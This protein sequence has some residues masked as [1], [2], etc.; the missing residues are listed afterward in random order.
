MRQLDPQHRGLKRVEAPVP[1]QVLVVVLGPLAIVAHH[2]HLLGQLP[3]IRRERAGVAVSSQVLARIEAEGAKRPDGPGAAPLVPGA[4]GL[5][6]VLDHR[7][8]VPGGDLEDRVHVGRLAVQVDGHDR[9]GA[10]RDGRFDQSRIDVVRARVDVDP[11]G[12][13]A[14]ERNC[15]RA[16]D[17]RSRRRDHLVARADVHRPHAQ[18]ERGHAGIQAHRVLRLAVGAKLAFEGGDVT[19][20]D[21]VG[22]RDHPTDR[23]LDLCRDGGLLRL[24]V[25]EWE[26]W[27]HAVP[28]F[29]R[30]MA[31]RRSP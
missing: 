24:Q 19:S 30:C 13:R 25:N 5:A 17:E 22:V 8:A 4:V 9:P 28:L 26:L 6:G 21:E 1:R 12:R 18:L 16:G 14:G 31:V 15:A 20:E 23:G 27:A 29:A 11:D 2:P 3:V 7:Q 10:W